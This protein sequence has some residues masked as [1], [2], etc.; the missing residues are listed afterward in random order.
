MSR[1]KGPT[2]NQVAKL[3]G[4]SQAIVSH[5]L[6]NNTAVSIPTETRQRVLDA[7]QRLG[8]EPDTNAQALRLG[9]TK[10]IGLII[11]DMHNPHFWQYV[12][13]VEQETAARGY[14]LLV[15]SMN[16]DPEQGKK[17]FKD[18]VR[19]QIDGL[20]LMGSFIK[21]SE[22]A[23]EILKRILQRGLAVVEITEHLQD[24]HHVDRV[25]GDY[26]L[27][28]T[29]LVS[30]LLALQHRRIGLIYGVQAPVLGED[31]LLPYQDSLRAA[32]LPV[33][34]ALV[35]RCGPAIED[36]Y[37]ATLQLLQLPSPPTALIAI[38]DLLAI[39]ALRAAEDL[40][41][42]VPRHL[43]IAGFDDIP[44][45]KYFVPRITTVTKETVGMGRTAVKLLIERINDR[46]RSLQ[47][48]NVT[49]QVVT[50]ESTGPAPA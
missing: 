23:R 39:G 24:D 38:N 29:E 43:S 42:Q 15:S 2:Q 37:Q 12:D 31:R 27:A 8:Y 47:T 50:R 11:P 48:V 1:V 22:E 30:H 14:S 46:S 41:L 5:V 49:A 34:D 4:V 19:Q 20:I 13:G 45:S 9:I 6:N 3:A 18:L 7:I 25:V 28:T 21:R 10:N 17:V 36:G 40:H 26:R 16:L 44:I 35:A 32:G 33:D